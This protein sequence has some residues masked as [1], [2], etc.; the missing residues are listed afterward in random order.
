MAEIHDAY[1]T[2][3]LHFEG[4]DA[5]TTFTDE[6]GTTWTKQGTAQID[7]AQKYFGAASGLFDGNS[8]Y[9]VATI[10]ANFDLSGTDWT[11]DCWFRSSS[12]A[13]V[14]GIIVKA[15]Y[16]GA[17]DWTVQLID[18]THLACYTNRANTNYTVTVPTMSVDTWY[19]V[20]YVR[21]ASTLHIYLNG[22]KYG[23]GSTMAITNDVIGTY[24]GIGC[25][26]AGTV[27]AQFFN[28]WIDELRVSK[29][30]A[31]WLGN[32]TPPT[33]PHPYQEPACY[34]GRQLDRFD[35]RPVSRRDALSVPSSAD[36][37]V[38]YT[39]SGVY[40]PQHTGPVEVLVVA[41]GGAG[42]GSQGQSIAS[43]GGGAGGLLYSTTEQ[44]VAGVPQ[45]VIVGHGGVGISGWV[46]GG[47][48]GNSRFGAQVATG[49]GGGGSW[50]VAPA[51][52]GSGGGVGEN[53]T[54]MS[55]GA[56]SQG[57]AGGTDYSTYY[58]GAESNA[59]GGG[60]K[61]AAGA[62]AP[63]ATAG[64]NGGAGEAYNIADGTTA[65]YYAGGGGGGGSTTA[66]TGGTGGG[67]TGASGS[68]GTGGAGTNN[69]GG[70]GG[71]SLTKAVEAAQ[72]GGNGGSGIVIVRW[73]TSYLVDVFSSRP[74]V[75]GGGT[76]PLVGQVSS[77]IFG[78]FGAPFR[79]PF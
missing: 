59:G 58:N 21:A 8:D 51:A 78:A 48:G 70:G 10:N 44:V 36:H 13:A 37:V 52:G 63:S 67:G 4:A 14:Q 26:F 34:L 24:V 49:G 6:L 25:T 43:G 62:N 23:T 69:Y 15:I 11:I 55:G 76:P 41:G 19:H 17:C 1:T 79:S 45:Q 39:A 30:I 72:P 53:N 7:T 42:G 75:Y 50:T 5:S 32:F 29:G 56:G 61:G 77:G 64:G 71:G 38:S 35:M 74:I 16:G 60:G 18:S 22:V 57:N 33:L 31:R 28:G 2:V 47:Q 12:F 40:V 73:L 65:V 3:M 46:V 27:P 54:V 20:A 68:T 66:G 9:L